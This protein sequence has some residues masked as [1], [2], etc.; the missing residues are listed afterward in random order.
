M[1]QHFARRGIGC[2]Y[3]AAATAGAA[4]PR[5][6]SAAAKAAATAMRIYIPVCSVAAADTIARTTSA[7]KITATRA[8]ARCCAIAATKP[9]DTRIAT[10][11]CCAVLPWVIATSTIACISILG[12]ASSSSYGKVNSAS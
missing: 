6:P 12:S 7:A 5:S 1:C 10:N 4:H 8:A 3:I 9:S 2:K 11:S